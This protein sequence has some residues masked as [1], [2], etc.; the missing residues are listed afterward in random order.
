MKNWLIF[1]LIVAGALSSTT[2]HAAQDQLADFVAAQKLE[3]PAQ[4]SFIQERQ[5]RGLPR[6]LVSSGSIEIYANQVIW[7]TEE[8]F[9]QQLIISP[10]GITEQ[11]SE[12]PVRGSAMMAQ[13][14]LAVLQGNINVIRDNFLTGPSDAN[15]ILLVPR[16]DR[17]REFVESISSCGSPKLERIELQEP[18]GNSSIIKLTPQ[19]PDVEHN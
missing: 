5:I 13:L 11:E 4:F 7:Q 12:T 2:L 15:C 19:T 14:L 6:P 17:V 3:L 18:A 16:S 10:D 8:P 1:M 9:S